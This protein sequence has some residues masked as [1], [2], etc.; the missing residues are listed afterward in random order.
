M[1]I[2]IAGAGGIGSNVAFQLVRGGIRCFKIVDFDCIEASNLNRQFYFSDQV[3]L[4]KAPTLVQN[5]KRIDPAI[6]AE[7]LQLRLDEGNMADT[8]A[9][10]D[11]VVEGFDGAREKKI[12]LEIFGGSDK[13]VVSACGVA[14]IEL[15]AVTTRRVGNCHIVGDFA[16]EAGTDNLYAP[17]VIMVASMMSQIVLKHYLSGAMA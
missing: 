6:Q 4:P 13:L 14:G 15:H 16:T 2:G 3:G 12:L 1:R 5:L 9:D 17:K 7:P 11:V 10:A 8:F